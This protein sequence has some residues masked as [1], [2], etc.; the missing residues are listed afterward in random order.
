[1]YLDYDYGK[2]K[3]KTPVAPK[4]TAAKM[5]KDA[6]DGKYQVSE[7]NDAVARAFAAA[8]P[9]LPA[10]QLAPPPAKPVAKPPPAAKPVETEEPLA[11]PAAA[12]PASP[13]ET[14]QPPQ[15]P[16]E[17]PAEPIETEEPPPEAAAAAGK[18]RKARK[19]W[20]PRKRPKTERVWVRNPAITDADQPA[21]LIV[22]I[23]EVDFRAEC[24]NVICA[25]G[26]DGEYHPHDRI[27]TWKIADLMKAY[28]A[29]PHVYRELWIQAAVGV[30]VRSL[31][32]NRL[33]YIVKGYVLKETPE[34]EAFWRR[35]LGD[36]FDA[37][38][39]GARAARY[40]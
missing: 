31:K 29:H 6:G 13:I 8:K 11:E 30:E 12:E 15:P 37:V 19:D 35:M 5:I 38:E 14:E 24:V 36:D 1:M 32:T 34:T 21:Y 4:A 17:E 40:W 25:P 18:K 22:A 28:A 2:G 7:L 26:P 20:Y 9:P 33:Q 27:E 16:P 10:A 39:G 3:K 23:Y